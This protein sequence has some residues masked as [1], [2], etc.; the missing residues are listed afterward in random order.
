MSRSLGV[1]IPCYDKGIEMPAV[2]IIDG[3]GHCAACARGTGAATPEPE[4]PYN[5]EVTRKPDP[6]AVKP[7]R[8]EAC[9]KSLKDSEARRTTA[10]CTRGCGRPTHRGNC[11][12][13]KATTGQVAKQNVDG[14]RRCKC[15]AL[16]HVGACAIQLEA[17]RMEYLE[18][19]P[20]KAKEREQR[21]DK[22]EAEEVSIEDVPE[23]RQSARKAQGR[24]GELWVKL[25][26]L[27]R[28]KALKVANRD[29]VHA[30]STT[31]HMRGRAKKDGYTLCARRDGSTVYL[32][33]NKAAA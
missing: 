28:G 12:G 9:L 19:Q 18:Q 7:L 5:V 2:L 27:E 6:P 4:N 21:M 20:I 10:R 26:A 8:G 31:Q 17:P 13:A 32:W 29:N 3:D 25:L 22:L 23:T 30:G 1:C 15:G 33:L 11:V 16:P 24:L 14:V